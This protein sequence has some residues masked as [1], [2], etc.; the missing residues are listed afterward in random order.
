LNVL[1]DLLGTATDFAP[2]I[3]TAIVVFLI[4]LLLAKIFEKLFH[5]AL[6]RLRFDSLMER[7]GLIDSLRRLGIRAE[8][9]RFLPRIIFWLAILVFL[10]SATREAGLASI[11]DAISALFGF[12][13]N[14][15]SAALIMILGTSLG[16]F[17]SRIVTNSARESGLSLARALGG[18]VS[19]LVLIVTVIIALAQ[20]K[21]DT[22]I[23]NILT[24]VIFSGFSLAFALTFG[25]GSREATKNM[26]A[27]FYARRLFRAGQEVE[28]SGERGTLRSITTT[29][30]IIESDGKTVAIPNSVFLDQV[31]YRL[32]EG[33]K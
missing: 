16:Q 25:L 30:T 1:Q 20:L 5:L 3:I 13:P 9:S 12:L 29:Q 19:G 7:A 17:L 33:R 31:V 2:R 24:I 6:S 26:I 15:I 23:L 18:A 8:P 27:G 4:G 22:R 10:Q 11:A 28:L 32:E 14:L 21:V